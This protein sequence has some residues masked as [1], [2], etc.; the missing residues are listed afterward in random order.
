MRP[1]HISPTYRCISVLNLYALRH[2]S[3]YENI[4]NFN[5]HIHT[6]LGHLR[7]VSVHD[8]KTVSLSFLVTFA[9]N[10]DA[11]IWDNFFCSQIIKQARNFPKGP[12]KLNREIPKEHSL[13]KTLTNCLNVKEP[14]DPNGNG[15]ISES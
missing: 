5:L 4:Q 13:N 15:V 2:S 11:I 14:L 3:T 10:F 7:S 1:L 6:D 12:S 9:T 8:F